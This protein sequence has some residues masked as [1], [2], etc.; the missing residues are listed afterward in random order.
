MNGQALIINLFVAV[1]GGVIAAAIASS[2]G[3][4]VAGWFFG[5]FFFPCVCII[6]VA[7]LS[8]LKQEQA[9]KEQVESEQRR[10]REQLRQERIKTESFRQFSA[11]RLDAH[12]RILGVDTRSAAALP[13][14]GG[15]PQALPPVAPGEAAVGGGQPL[16]PVEELARAVG[17]PPPA[18]GQSSLSPEKAWYYEVAGAPKGPAS[19]EDIR[20]YLWAGMINAK[21]LLWCEDLVQWTAAGEVDTFRY[22]A[23]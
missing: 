3:R 1:I 20:Q 14:A 4:S 15:V 19:T 22:E 23:I 13:G 16:T 21:T 5:G 11:S 9:Y 17:G 12:D 6:V 8:N 7:C 18:P 2:K 10:L